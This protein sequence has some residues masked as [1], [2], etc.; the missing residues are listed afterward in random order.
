MA[1]QLKFE[2]VSPERLLLSRD[3]EGV[4]IP[5]AD[6]DLTV[7][8]AHM[9][10]MTTIRPG[11]IEVMGGAV[12]HPRIFV[13]GGFAEI[14]PQGLTV[15]AEEAIPMDQVDPEKLAQRISDLREDVADAKD[16]DSRLRASDELSD[17]L[18]IQASL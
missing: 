16:D 2:L 7:L 3:V 11:V 13:G 12:D 10:L 14:T 4:V 1:D 18:Q 17:L 15:L 5:G 8:P 9:P 6:G